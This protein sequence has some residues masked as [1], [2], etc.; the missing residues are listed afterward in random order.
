MHPNRSFFVT[1]LRRRLSAKRSI[2]LGFSTLLVIIGPSLVVA[3]QTPPTTSN[4]TPFE[5]SP[6]VVSA[7]TDQGYA[8]R[9]T[10][11]GTRTRTEL[12]DVAATVGV[13]TQEFIND[14]AATNENDI[15]AYSA[16]AV[17]EL[18]DQTNNMQG[19]S[20][21]QPGNYQFRIR[22]QTATRARNYFDTL[23]PPDT[24]NIERFE[25]AR[26][27][28]AILFGLGGAGGIL[29]QTTKRANLSRSK[30][31]VTT[32]SGNDELIRG[33]LDSN[34]VLMDGR[35]A[36][37]LNAVYQDTAGW[38]PYE[39]D[40][41]KRADLAGTFQLNPKLKLSIELERGSIH[42]SASRDFGANDGLSLWLDK[43]RTQVATSAANA[44]AGIALTANQ[45]RITVIGN[46]GS[47]HN[48]QQT[49]VSTTDAARL[50]GAITEQSLVPFDAFI[51]G[52]GSERFVE[53]N[54]QSAFLELNPV[55]NL[56]VE[57][58]ADR[59]Y[60]DSRVYDTTNGVYQLL[61]EPGQS[62][63]D[64]AANPYA[65]DLYFD[66]RWV[67]RT[68]RETLTNLRA[69]ASYTMDLGRAGRHNF[70]VMAQQSRDAYFTNNLVPVVSGSPFNATPSN[71][72]NQINTR[73]YIT[74][75]ADLNQ[76]AVAGWRS[77]PS[78]I[79]VSLN[80]GAV[81]SVYQSV[82][83]TNSTDI[84]DDSTVVRSYLASVQS[85][86]LQDRLVA[87]F[88][89]R[90]DER[91]AYTHS[92]VLDPTSKIALVDYSRQ[93]ITD[94]SANQTSL[95]LVG[96]VTPWLSLFYNQSQNAQIPGTGNLLIPDNSLLPISRGKGKDAG[97]NLTLLD[98][99]LSARVAYFV[100]E[101]VDVGKAYTAG[102]N[103][104]TRNDRILDT[105]IT[106][107]IL[108][109][110][111]AAALRFVGSGFDLLDRRTTG[112]ELSVTANPTPHWRMI[113]N[114]SQGKSVED[115]L[116]KRTRSIKDA[117]LATWARA[118]PTSVTANS[119]TVAQE[120]ADFNTWFASNTSVEGESSL[121][122]RE[123]QAKFFN[124]YD[125]SEGL[126]RGWFVGGGLRYQSSPVIGVNGT[127]GLYYR[128]ESS[129]EMD[130]LVG[131]QTKLQL[132][133]HK[134]NLSVQ[135]NGKD[136][137]HQHDYLSLRRDATGL[138]TNIRIVDPA[139][140][141]LQVKLE[142]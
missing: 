60:G 45:Q 54:V 142:F 126:F 71:N 79:S 102:A 52:P 56:Y 57:L 55:R 106:D 89:V 135:L 1:R 17:P 63:R 16:S 30:T 47:V 23:T 104:A 124:R 3:Q 108:T 87:N 10:L 5:L 35:F 34:Q 111:D 125:F 61:G 110:A 138:L 128:G 94:A 140:Y 36:L 113:F 62:Y 112:W 20:I 27:P 130:L 92:T 93:D 6:F 139:S 134:T 81:P 40:H 132:W 14:L 72:R 22:G 48:F 67:Q 117:M 122:D 29:N 38:R 83:I 114:G 66:T 21:I 39:F 11:S 123:W 115:N 105:M 42:D 118:K 88:G 32:Q 85:Y 37:R 49:P 75:P 59:Q 116:L 76:Y 4:E 50:G 91:K 41:E 120:I 137:L 46:D 13:F 131:Y 53:Y 43:G 103:T 101:M 119:I 141:S 96:H 31:V 69:T 44:G 64:G 99:R 9:D 86:F 121:G 65:G 28:N 33:S 95:G 24:Y 15:M 90:R 25:E 74:N 78:E 19:I 12:K 70:A 84:S 26:G 98:G 80:K 18:T 73:A 127:T 2:R 107:G 68:R 136:L 109:S 8:A 97:F 77:I 7:G 82:W 100:T 58:A 133:G 51:P 129:T